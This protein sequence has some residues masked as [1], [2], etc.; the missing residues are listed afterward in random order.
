MKMGVKNLTFLIKIQTHML[1]LI[2][3]IMQASFKK[4]IQNK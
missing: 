3:I 1:V 4:N 2:K